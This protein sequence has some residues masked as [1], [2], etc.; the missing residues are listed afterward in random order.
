MKS[1]L[2]ISLTLLLSVPLTACGQRVEVSP[3]EV[4]RIMTKDGYQEQTITTSKFRLSPCL[5]YCDKLVKIDISD[6]VS[7]ES[8]KIFMPK[9]KLNLDVVVRGTLSINPNNIDSLFSK[10]PAEEGN[11]NSYYIKK[12]TIYKVYAQNLIQSTVREYLTNFSIG[13]VSSSLD[14]INS[15]LFGIV[16][17]KLKE[18]TPFVV[19]SFGVVNINYPNIITKAQENAAQ[20]REQ[21]QQEEAQ[22]EISKVSLERELQEARLKR[23]IEIE[24]AQTEATAQKIQREVVDSRVLELRRIEVQRE[25]IQ[26]WDG[27]LPHIQSGEGNVPMLFQIQG[28]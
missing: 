21:I 13:E 11:D 15:E 17:T 22:L 20:R 9:D 25:W 8:L 12:D 7:S 18:N 19:R 14:V 4:G 10:V 2:T 6:S 23:Q 26:K 5:A 16:S 3:T 1:F 27:K 24:K 28:K